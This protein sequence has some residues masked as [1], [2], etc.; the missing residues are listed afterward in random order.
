MEGA[1]V[2]PDIR[3]FL[4]AA[5]NRYHRA[6]LGASRT[7][8]ATYSTSF[9]LATRLLS[10]Q[11]RADIRNLY[12]VVR[13]ADEIVDGT[14]AAAGCA[15]D[16]IAQLLD[17]YE[18]AVLTAP[19]RRF[20]TDLILQAYADTARRC[21]FREDHVRAFFASMRRDLSA[22]D[23]DSGSFDD[24]VHGSA[25]VI[26]LLCLSVF[27]NGRI[28]GVSRRRELEE[29]ARSL[30]AAFQ[31]INFL[32]D[33]AEDQTQLGRTYFPGLRA[34]ELT[35]EHKNMLIDDI[36]LDLDRARG[37]MGWLPLQARAG[38]LAALDLF[39]SLTDTI[40]ATPAPELLNTRIRVRP[41]RKA[42]IAAAAVVRAPIMGIRGAAS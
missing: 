7:V 21:G 13:I 12:A 15:T 40:A 27:L 28:V 31:K 38:V 29:G 42:G 4:E 30:G 1:E 26:G 17:D 41:L 35:E 22:K 39:S 36:R 37:V 33:L 5:L 23:H 2:N 16:S 25:E 8:I 6:S 18:H 3:A 10:A 34:G 32:R 19:G 11:M 14:A 9:S 20:H 24:Y